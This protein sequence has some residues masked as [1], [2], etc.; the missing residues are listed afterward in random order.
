MQRLAIFECLG[1]YSYFI[2]VLMTLDVENYC[3]TQMNEAAD[4][5][6]VGIY[7]ERLKKTEISSQVVCETLSY[8][9]PCKYQFAVQNH[10]R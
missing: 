10:L 2:P 1:Y 9:M 7:Y 8:V 4:P 6:L 5:H 3:K